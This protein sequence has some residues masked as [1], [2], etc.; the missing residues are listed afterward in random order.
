MNDCR[1][2]N[3]HDIL[4]RFRKLISDIKNGEK[5]SDEHINAASQL[6]RGQFEDLQELCSPV[7]GQKLSFPKFEWASGY[8]GY[9]YFQ[10]LHTGSDHWIA[11]KAISESEVYVYDSIFMQPT[12]YTLKQIASILHAPSSQILLHLERVQM[13]SNSVDC[14]V[15]AIAF[16]TDLCYGK[17]PASCRYAS[18]EICNHLVTCF[19]NGHMT[20]FPSTSTVKKKKTLMKQVT[21]YCQCRLPYVLEHM[22]NPG[23]E[24]VDMVQCFICDNLYHSSCVNLSLDQAKRI[25]EQKKCGYVIIKVLTMHLEIYLIQTRWLYLHFE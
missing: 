9:A 16:L 5:L 19:E 13:Q 6:L 22:K 20:P 14:G 15:Y 12:Y 24:V 17:D 3:Q 4:E 10:I 11:I 23:N 7:L 2:I 1:I 8:A 18:T 25:K 21:V